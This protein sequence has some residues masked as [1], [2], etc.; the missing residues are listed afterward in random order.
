ML[1]CA[2]LQG[3]AW[4][5][6]LDAVS[7]QRSLDRVVGAAQLMGATT[8]CTSQLCRRTVGPRLL[9]R[10][11]PHS[12]SL[13]LGLAERHSKRHT[14]KPPCNSTWWKEV[15]STVSGPAL[16]ACREPPL[17]DSPSV[18]AGSSAD[19]DCTTCREKDRKKKK[20]SDVLRTAGCLPSHQ[21]HG[22]MRSFSPRSAI[23]P[24]VLANFKKSQHANST[25][26]A[27]EPTY[28]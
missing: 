14:R 5:D 1:T 4:R 10:A 11:L 3:R 21:P 2:T 19:C 20:A 9:W 28:Q 24:G 17:D 6:T 13:S 15:K 18:E 27:H 22:T 25:A 16:C 23:G 26:R 7:A 8:T 12:R